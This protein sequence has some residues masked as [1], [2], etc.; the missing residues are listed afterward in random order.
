MTDLATLED[1]ELRFG[2]HRKVSG[3]GE[4][5][6]CRFPCPFC[7]APDWYVVPALEFGR[8]EM[9]PHYCIECE[10]SARFLFS[11]DRLDQSVNA[12]LVQ[13]SGPPTPEWM[14]QPRREG[15]QAVVESAGRLT[16]VK[17]LPR[18]LRTPPRQIEAPKD[19]KLKRT[20]T[21][22]SSNRTGTRKS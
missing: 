10:R 16:P 22:T 5:A 19:G 6:L 8:G 4:D 3:R 9:E 18:K 1:Y 15:D 11:A 12:E 13:C 14:K 21:T 2:Q 17:E 7:A 20:T